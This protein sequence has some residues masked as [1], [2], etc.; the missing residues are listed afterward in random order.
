MLCPV[1]GNLQREIRFVDYRL[2]YARDFISEDE[3]VFLSLLGNEAVE[4]D[5]VHCLF[6]ADDGIAFG[7][8]AGDGVEGAVGMFPGDAVFGSE[9]GFVDFCRRGYCQ[10]LSTLKA[11]Q[12]LNAEPTLWAL[13]MLSR[14]TAMPEGGSPLYSSADTL[15]SSMFSSFLSF[16]SV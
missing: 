13:R 2:F 6:D 9:G 5:G 4:L 8:E 11:S 3:G 7:L 1:L 14:T 16:M 15:P 10:I 12:L